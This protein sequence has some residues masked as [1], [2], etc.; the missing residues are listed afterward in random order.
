MDLI[1]Q[2]SIIIIIFQISIAGS[3][4]YPKYKNICKMSTFTSGL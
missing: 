4:W 3:D 2:I 1:S